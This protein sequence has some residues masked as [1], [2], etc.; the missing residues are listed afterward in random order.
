V[1]KEKNVAKAKN[2]EKYGKIVK[3]VANATFIR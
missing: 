3:N 2:V 1:A